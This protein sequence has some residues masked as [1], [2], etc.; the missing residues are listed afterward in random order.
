[1]PELAIWRRGR[2]CRW[3][4]KSLATPAGAMIGAVDRC[5]RGGPGS[6][7]GLRVG[8]STA[9]GLAL[10]TGCAVVGVPTLV[11]LAAVAASAG[12][13]GLVCPLLDARKGE[14]Y[15]ALIEPATAIDSSGCRPTSR[16]RRRSWRH[17]LPISAIGRARS[18]ATPSS[19][20]GRARVRIGLFCLRRCHPRGAVVAR[21]GWQ[22]RLRRRRRR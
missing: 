6:F 9:K 19:W 8:L 20:C 15:G 16:R 21:L 10:A 13:R 1:L 18:S 14:V 11:A 17:P 4:T 7:T 3:S 2:C 12:R 22:S 5:R